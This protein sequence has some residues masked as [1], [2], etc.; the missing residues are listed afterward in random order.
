MLNSSKRVAQA[1]PE[2]GQT[3]I[4]RWVGL[5][6]SVTDSRGAQVASTLRRLGR[7]RLVTLPL[8]VA[9]AFASLLGVA[10]APVGASASGGG[11]TV[12]TYTGGCRYG[13]VDI[14]PQIRVQSGWVFVNMYA[15][16]YNANGRILK[17]SGGDGS[18]V[19]R[20]FYGPSRATWPRW[21]GSVPRGGAYVKVFVKNADDHLV[22]VDTATC[23]T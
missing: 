12:T 7:R 10:P 13:Y 15:A 5:V 2:Q 18:I 1:R 17:T 11:I 9:I 3:L 20:S 14:N 4:H 19:Y 22:L 16:L 23:R 6:A 8:A 21:Q